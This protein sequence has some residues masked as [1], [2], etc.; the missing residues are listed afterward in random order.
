MKY[1][2]LL[3]T[4]CMFSAC[5]K[6]EGYGPYKLK[7]GQEVELLISHR[8]DAMGDLPLL[9]AQKAYPGLSLAGFDSREPGFN[10]LVKAKMVV[11]SGPVMMDGG[12]SDHLNFVK[13]ISKEKYAGNE[14]F[15]LSLVRSIVP[16]P[17]FVTLYKEGDLYFY[18]T[19]FGSKIQLSY[20]DVQVGEQLAEIWEFN[21]NN[22]SYNNAPSIPSKWKSIVATVT[23][24]PENFGKAYLV[25]QLKLTK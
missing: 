5:S 25:S 18:I 14:S 9:A 11:Y 16:G 19:A 24:D 20:T 12:P 10:Y 17:N 7:D 21:K 15:E 22:F 8:Y 6:E 2:Y 3:L 1:I 23:H 4:L 13:V